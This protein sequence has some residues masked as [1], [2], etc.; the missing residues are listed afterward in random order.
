MRSVTDN[1][2]EYVR[3]TGVNISKMA[4]DTGI[5]YMSLYDSLMNERRG[6]VLRDWEMLRICKFLGVNPMNFARDILENNENKG[7]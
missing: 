6:R 2:S 3:N 4:R 7:A 5:P 1:I